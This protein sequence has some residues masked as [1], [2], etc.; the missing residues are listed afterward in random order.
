MRSILTEK[1]LVVNRLYVAYDVI[2]VQTALCDCVQG[3]ACPIDADMIAHR[4]DAWLKLENLPADARIIQS[5][6]GPVQVPYVVC[7][8]NYDRIPPARKAKRVPSNQD[9][10]ERDGNICQYSGDYVPAPHGTVD[11]VIPKDKGGGEDWTNKVWCRKD[12]NFKKK[13]R[14]NHEVGYKLLRKPVVPKP[15][16]RKIVA[17]NSRWQA[18]VV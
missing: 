8:A 16:R 7:M 10:A 15:R 14:Y 5:A 4:W 13:N 1:V 11:H 6:R 12:L 3:K 9:I 2:D 18:F 17:L